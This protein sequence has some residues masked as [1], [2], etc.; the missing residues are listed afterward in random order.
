MPPQIRLPLSCHRLSYS[1]AFSGPSL[2]GPT[3]WFELRV[4]VGH[5]IAIKLLHSLSLLVSEKM[6]DAVAALHRS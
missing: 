4:A 3:K 2:T 5:P 6:M 1:L